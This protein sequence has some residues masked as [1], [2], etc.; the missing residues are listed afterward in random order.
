MLQQA[1]FD[2]V[3]LNHRVGLIF[4]EQS[5]K[6]TLTR[7]AG[8]FAR[9]VLHVPDVEVPPEDRRAALEAL[10]GRALMYDTWGH[11][12]WDDVET[13]VRFMHHAQ[14]IELFYLDHL[15]AMADPQREKESLEVLMEAM[16]TLAHELNIIIHYVSHLTTP[17]SGSHEEGARVTIRSFKG[18]R[19]IGYWSHFMFGLERNQQADD[20][21]EKRITTFRVLKD[22]FT[23]RST[24][25]TFLLDYDPDTGMLFPTEA[26]ESDEH[27]FR[28][29]EDF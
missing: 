24:G 1:S 13:Q 9:R 26:K 7:L 11:A 25:D 21:N 20:P 2:A 29:D 15:T 5:P 3:K 4:L 6:E 27:G 14:G 8:K 18:S 17:D 28:E 19:A 23:G 22:R 16:A 12:N 10:R